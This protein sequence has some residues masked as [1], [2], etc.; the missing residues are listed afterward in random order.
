MKQK[1]KNAHW[2]EAHARQLLEHA[3]KHNLSIA[4]LARE[5]GVDARRIYWWRKR[6][7]ATPAPKPPTFVEVKLPAPATHPFAIRTSSGRTVEVWPGFDASELARLIAAV[8][9]ESC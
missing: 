8:E 4:E 1:K 5:Q 3:E 7:Q 9:K 2:K 6:L